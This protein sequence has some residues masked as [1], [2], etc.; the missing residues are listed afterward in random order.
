M[1]NKS[2]DVREGGKL[3][4]L[5]KSI[6]K[7]LENP[8]RA[9]DFILIYLGR[10]FGHYHYKKFIVLTRS[11]T[12]SNLLIGMLNSHP[13]IYAKQGIF[14]RLDGKSIDDVLNK[15][16]S[17]YPNWIKAVGFK[18]FYYHPQDDSSGLIWEKLLNIKDFYVIHLTRKN[19][20]KTILSREIAGTTDV[21]SKT[22]LSNSIPVEK[23]KVFLNK[24]EL[25][26]KFEETKS[27]EKKFRKLFSGKNVVNLTYE[28]F[29]SNPQTEFKRIC[30]MLNL[31]YIY[32]KTNFKKQNPETLKDLIVNYDDLKKSFS[33]SEWAEFFAD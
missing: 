27:W 32:P 4:P 21:W 2:F 33:N 13:S 24:E 6:K 25:I 7:A 15:I 16:Y 5:I 10:I 26:K 3:Q 19:I 12:G 14:G 29:L 9:K 17:K 18:I 8:K 11:R 1:L 28:D 23:R 30:D 20:L 31:K 22:S